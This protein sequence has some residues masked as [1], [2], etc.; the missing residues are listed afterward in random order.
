VRLSG[1]PS[2]ARRFRRLS[3]RQRRA[4]LAAVW[5]A[6][7]YETTVE[8][9]GVTARRDD[10]TLRIGLVG[11][12][13][14]GDSEADLLVGTRDTARARSYAA[15]QGVEFLGP[16]EIRD[17]LLYGLDRAAAE[18]I[19]REWMDRP[20]SAFAAHTRDEGRPT[21]AVRASAYA[22]A[23]A[24]LLVLAGGAIFAGSFG[25][26]TSADGSVDASEL[27]TDTATPEP[28]DT[29]PASGIDGSDAP[30]GDELLEAHREQLQNQS[31][32]VTVRYTKP[33]NSTPP[34]PTLVPEVTRYE[35]TVKIGAEGRASLSQTVVSE[36]DNETA[37]VRVRSYRRSGV[38][39]T[40]VVEKNETGETNNA[41]Y[42]QLVRSPG[43]F[44][45]TVLD[46]ERTFLDALSTNETRM[47]TV[48]RTQEPYRRVRV[49]ATG[50]PER[51]AQ[52]AA[53]YRANAILT[54]EGRFV[55]LAASYVDPESG[56]NVSL[57][58]TIGGV[59]TTEVDIPGWAERAAGGTP[60]E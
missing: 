18:G 32:T 25:A 59:S 20:L 30:F 52:E 38:V 19:V 15:D 39:R 45:G 1:G 57:T 43:P 46:T 51:W 10:E 8:N 56:E 31:F 35:R 21:S 7:G 22:V 47:D 49:T 53:E 16:A 60:E 26:D 12:W 4:F 6:R 48:R 3:D 37:R 11:W 36:R 2:F 42:T 41:T 40:R 29:K 33:A 28:T 14:R 44:V 58:I 55:L 50:E 27:A 24:A 17:L 34:V 13:P 9:D 23:V 5:S 54:T